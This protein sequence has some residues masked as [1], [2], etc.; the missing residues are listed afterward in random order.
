L[1]RITFPPK[2]EIFKQNWIYAFI[3]FALAFG[4][5]GKTIGF[6]YAWDD[7]IV[8]TQNER[9]Q[10]GIAGIS[11]HFKERDRV[12]LQDFSGFRPITMSSFSIDY[13]FFGLHPAWGHFV[14]IF[15]YGLVC[16][17]IF[18]TILRLFPDQGRGFAFMISLLFL[19]HPIHVEAV[20][21]IKS[22]DEIL[23]FL[24]ILFGML[25]FWKFHNSRNFI[26][27]GICLTTISAAALSKENGILSPILLVFSLLFFPGTSRQ[28][29]Q[30][31]IY[32]GLLALLLV[33]VLWALTSRI[34]GQILGDD[35]IG[36]LESYELGNSLI[37]AE[38]WESIGNGSRLIWYYL[39]KFI[40]PY[41]LTY[42]SG[43][44]HFPFWNWENPMLWASFSASLLLFFWLGVSILRRH[45]SLLLFGFGF[46]LITISIYLQIVFFL[47]DTMA[48][49]FMFTPSFGLCISLAFLIKYLSRKLGESMTFSKSGNF[50]YPI[51]AIII[52][53]FSL[54][55]F[56]RMDAWKDTYTLVATDMGKLENCSRAHYFMAE[57]ISK[58]L[59]RHPNNLEL[60]D[61]MFHHYKRS[62]EITK[63]A[64][65]S[66]WNWSQYL[67]NYGKFKEAEA[68]LLQFAKVYPYQADPWFFLGKNEFI[69]NEFDSSATHLE[70]SFFLDSGIFE[71]REIW[72]K[73]MIKTGN[74]TKAEKVALSGVK[75]NP[76]SIR[77]WDALADVYFAKGESEKCFKVMDRILSTD[78]NNP[79]WW[80]KMIG[81][82]QLIQ[83][84]ERADFY[85]REAKKIGVL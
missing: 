30:S 85:Y 4:L 65:Y 45:R 37:G 54:M 10:R 42:Y 70:R 69:L 31:G 34:P 49:R 66:F 79:F 25:S 80:K 77:L 82:Q 21:N 75:S 38:L 52:L 61:K 19:A 5:Y 15:I 39:G 35:P 22:R 59:A 58:K 36:F 12:E 20:A 63:M 57:E 50:F 53:A 71:T 3:I 81:F 23:A 6:D 51:A 40:F 76:E 60:Q 55:S 46:F 26:W 9:V 7:K 1:T 17:L 84:Q 16:V 24:F 72:V 11:E 62:V 64:Y 67:M 27:L 56:N 14:N 18:V 32:I 74:L 78:P 83:D 44:N 73:A 48:D 68:V 41:D 8:I 29:I 28:K 43:Y 2:L 47:A 13:E 33:F